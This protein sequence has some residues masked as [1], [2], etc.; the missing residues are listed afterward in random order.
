MTARSRGRNHL[1]FSAE[2]P[3]DGEVGEG[4]PKTASGETPKHPLSEGRKERRRGTEG[5]SQPP[6]LCSTGSRQPNG[7]KT[8]RS[9]HQEEPG[10]S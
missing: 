6:S 8:R 2:E 3:E 1:H 9:P 5:P 4:V 10:H 7:V